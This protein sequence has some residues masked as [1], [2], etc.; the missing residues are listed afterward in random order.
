MNWLSI[1]I[2]PENLFRSHLLC[3]VPSLARQLRFFFY[4]G[5]ATNEYHANIRVLAWRA[6]LRLCQAKNSINL[7]QIPKSKKKVWYK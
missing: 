5:Y 2:N 7:W 4:L 3:L 1:C 6:P